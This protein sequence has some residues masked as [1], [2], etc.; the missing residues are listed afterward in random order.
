[1][2]LPNSEDAHIPREK[3]TDYLLSETHPV[4][5]AKARVLREMGFDES[6]INDLLSGLLK[7]AHSEE[8]VEVVSSLY[9]IKYVV[10]G[11][12]QSPEG[13]RIRL[14]TVW[15][16]DAGQHRPRFVTAYPA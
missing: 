5:R 6:S 2:K 7:I 4:G 1:M 11:D 3:V 15:I 16:V 14:R 9:G 8:V 12:L 13:A 10:E